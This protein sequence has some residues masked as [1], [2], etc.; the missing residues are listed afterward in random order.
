LLILVEALPKA[1]VR[2][3]GSRPKAAANRPNTVVG[4]ANL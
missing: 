1:T 2:A 4:S 3:G